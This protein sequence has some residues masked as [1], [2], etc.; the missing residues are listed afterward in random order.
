MSAYSS[1]GYSPGRS[2]WPGRASRSSPRGYGRYDRYSGQPFLG[3]SLRIPGRILS[4]LEEEVE[5][6]IQEAKQDYHPV[7]SG[8]WHYRRRSCGSGP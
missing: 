1:T 2:L 6:A 7:H 4:P 3:R 8:E 5:R